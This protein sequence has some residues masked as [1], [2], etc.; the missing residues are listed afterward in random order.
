MRKIVLL[1]TL[2]ASLAFSATINECKTDVYFGN[3]ILTEDT[4]AEKNAGIIEKAIKK[5]YGL[6]YYNKHI[7][8]V[9][10]AYNQTSGIVVDLLESAAQKLSLQA[11][12][13][14]F[15]LVHSHITDHLA[16]SA[17]QLT[18]YKNSIM[19]GHRVL[20][21]AHS[22]GNFYAGELFKQLPGWMQDYFE[23]VSVASPMNDPIKDGTPRIDWDN[24]PV[25][26]V[27]SAGSRTSNPV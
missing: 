9:T 5:K 25:A 4:G 23:A 1:L 14:A 13:D 8:K 26:H 10:Y 27:S 15:S 16:D 21:V 7:G 11:L 18:A 17:R 2:F 24:D 20:V 19:Q 12:I 3:G 22:Q 6:D